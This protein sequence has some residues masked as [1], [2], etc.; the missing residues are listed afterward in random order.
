MA[1]VMEGTVPWNDGEN[2]MRAK[3]RVPRSDNPSSP[4][5]TPYG[6]YMVSTAPLLGVG[7]LD[8]AGQPWASVW[9]GEPGFANVVDKDII[10]MRTL[11]D[12]VNDPVVEALL[13]KNADGTVVVA[14]G[15]GKMVGGLAIDL[16]K[17]TRVKLYGR[18]VAGTVTDPEHSEPSS[19]LEGRRG[20]AQLVVKIGESLGQ[21]TA[22]DA[23]RTSSSWMSAADDFIGNCPK[24]LHKKHIV[25]AIPE[26]KLISD[27]PQLH[28][29]A[30]ELL[31]RADCLFIS[32]SHHDVD[33]DTNYRGGPQGFVRVIS[34]EPSGAVLIYPEY[35][36]NRLYQ[37]LGNMTMNPRAGI[38]F[39]DFETG[40]ALYITGTTEILVGADADSL[41]PGSNLAIKVTVTGA[42]YVEK[43]LGF[44]GVPV[45]MSPYTPSVRYL[46][47]E[48]D[49]PVPS[50]VNADTVTAKLIK[51]D[52]LSPT[53]NRFRFKLTGPKGS[54]KYNPG[55]YA[56]FSFKDELDMG[57]SHMR[58]D[59]PLSINDDY[60]RTF[61]VSS[62]PG[63]RIP[64]DEFEI[65]VRRHQNVTS[66]L[67]R[68][69]PRTELT[70]PLLAF[71]GSFRIDDRGENSIVPF[72]AGGIG[73]TPLIG[74]LP[75][76]DVSRLRLFWSISAEDIGLVEDT[77]QNC[78]DLLPVTKLFIT[79]A[80]EVKDCDLLDRLKEMED[81]PAAV[82]RRRLS[83]EDLDMPA[84]TFY[85]CSGKALQAS[86][87][88]W[89]KGKNVISEDF[90]Y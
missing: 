52:T 53:I 76:I 33:M 56:I 27:T 80:D 16:E 68:W 47:T 2:T 34:N 70:V 46:R 36:G 77:F 60:I 4:F 73:I 88:G 35:S 63:R 10:G 11:I 5:L 67:S 65:T 55:Q 44:R 58:D 71:G 62:F 29:N 9:G 24:Y 49:H 14:D 7:A 72:I 64:D 66:Y 25:P 30:V 74:Q 75:G 50:V 19:K 85:L 17:R 28:P 43:G 84:H 69:H 79:R 83:A 38:V 41:L 15:K 61:T 31:S 87:R 6:A 40:N 12:R 3:M 48:K 1:V 42:R 90:V 57:Y 37:S 20:Q 54:P 81:S 82:N 26:P 89:L 18:M 86:V 51:K 39:P 78:P 45:D 23:F 21:S 22:R 13:G 32:S 8:S 59:D